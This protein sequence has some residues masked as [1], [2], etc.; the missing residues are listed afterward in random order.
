MLEIQ[1]QR[2]IFTRLLV[3]AALLGGCGET[4]SDEPAPS[5]AKKTEGLAA[6]VEKQMNEALSGSEE[7][8]DRKKAFNDA[9]DGLN[10][11]HEVK[12]AAEGEEAKAAA[13]TAYDDAKVRYDAALK[14]L[15]DARSE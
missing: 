13:Q 3:L 1:K 8:Q 4:K 7:V 9:R 14:A 5:K 10:A 2:S 12:K 11:A 15:G 6:E